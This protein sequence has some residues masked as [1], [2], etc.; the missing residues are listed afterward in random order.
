MLSADALM[1]VAH[2]RIADLRREVE[3]D[4]LVQLAQTRASNDA[5][6]ALS[7]SPV[8]RQGRGRTQFRQEWKFQ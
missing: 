7:R 5:A 3:A 1:V 6:V 8:P 4:R 2:E